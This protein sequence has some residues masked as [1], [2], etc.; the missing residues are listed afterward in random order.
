MPDSHGAGG[1]D[2][3]RINRR[4]TARF[5][6]VLLAA[7][8][9]ATAAS[10]AEQAK[11][12]AVPKGP[13]PAEATYDDPLGRSTP[14]GTVLG[15]IRSMQRG[16]YERAID[17]LDTRQ[18]GKR[19]QQLAAGR[20]GPAV[21]GAHDVAARVAL[22][23]ALQ[24]AAPAQHD[25]LAVA[26]AVGEQLDAAIGL[27]HQRAPAFFLRQHVVVARLG[28]GMGMADIARPLLEQ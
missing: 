4:W 7:A 13:V 8:L 25:G 16:D 1:E 12:A 5:V 27:A 17:Y 14:Q 18:T 11:P 6:T 9:I 28:D 19:A 3:M 24:V 10:A 23:L 2:A 22:A 26:A 21:D 15:F 20:V